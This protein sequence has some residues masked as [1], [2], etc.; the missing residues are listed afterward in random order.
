MVL[1]HLVHTMTERRVGF[2]FPA[3]A[4]VSF[5]VLCAIHEVQAE[6]FPESNCED[7]GFTGL[8]LCSDC[9][10]LAEYVIDKGNSTTP[11]PACVGIFIDLTFINP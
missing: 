6:G 3:C 2:R 9:D 1:T 7:L 4:F 5:V 10:S 8:A 11:R